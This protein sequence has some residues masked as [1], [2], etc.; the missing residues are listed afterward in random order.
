MV[1]TIEM[2]AGDTILSLFKKLKNPGDKIHV[3]DEKRLRWRSIGQEATRENK[4]ARMLNEI[5]KHEV[6]YSVSIAEK[7][8]YTTIR[9]IDN[10]KV[11][12]V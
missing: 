10:V 4:Y 8:G 2:K 12:A 7:E 3:K 9:Y 5:S 6:K 11:E 1:R